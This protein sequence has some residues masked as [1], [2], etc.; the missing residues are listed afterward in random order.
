MKT[1]PEIEYGSKEQ[2]GSGVKNQIP[3][4]L[5]TYILCRTNIRINRA[6]GDILHTQV[7]LD[8]RNR[9]GSVMTLEEK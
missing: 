7:W 8:L 6:V 9:D 2:I 3:H 4:R 1:I 5:L